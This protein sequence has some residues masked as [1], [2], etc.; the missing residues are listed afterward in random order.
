MKRPLVP[1][2][3]PKAA[4]PSS[5]PHAALGANHL[6]TSPWPHGCERVG[7]AWPK[8]LKSSPTEGA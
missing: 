8:Q 2:G 1:R 6:F 7:L 5:P 3:G 4:R